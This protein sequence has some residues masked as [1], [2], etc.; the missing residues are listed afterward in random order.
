M[1]HSMKKEFNSF[2]YDSNDKT[3]KIR[4]MNKNLKGTW[5]KNKFAEWRNSEWLILLLFV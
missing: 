4:Y 1:I 5:K 3:V 2:S